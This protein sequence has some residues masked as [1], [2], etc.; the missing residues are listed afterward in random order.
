LTLQLVVCSRCDFHGAAVYKESRRGALDSEIWDH[1]GYH[2]DRLEWRR[3]RAL[4]NRCRSPGQASCTC[5]SH[6]LLGRVDPQTGRWA[7]VPSLDQAA[8]FPMR[9]GG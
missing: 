6:R 2:L 1:A 9:R 4:I 8:A 3:L 5:E 7:G